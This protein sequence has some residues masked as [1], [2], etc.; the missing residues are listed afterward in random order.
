MPVFLFPLT[1]TPKLT[2]ALNSTTV[3]L[4]LKTIHLVLLGRNITRDSIQIPQ[5]PLD[6]VVLILKK[7]HMNE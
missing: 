2:L 6:M 7:M 1:P 4:K 3:E 5:V